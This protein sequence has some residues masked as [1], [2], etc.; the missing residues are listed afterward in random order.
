MIIT[1][2]FDNRE[3]WYSNWNDSRDDNQCILAKSSMTLRI[4]TGSL[5]RPEIIIFTI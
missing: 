1:R 2:D 3:S 5:G 4:S